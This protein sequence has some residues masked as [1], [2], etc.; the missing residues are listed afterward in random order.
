MPLACVRVRWHVCRNVS[1]VM[2]DLRHERPG[3]GG[4][5]SEAAEHSKCV[6]KCLQPC[7]VKEADGR[8]QV[9]DEVRVRTSEG[10]S[11]SA[12]VP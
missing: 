4:W 8:Q 7:R 5:I 10:G 11:P 12:V 1:D 9:G 6:R 3:N 2:L